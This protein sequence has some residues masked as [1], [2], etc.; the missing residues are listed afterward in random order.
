[1]KSTIIYVIILLLGVLYAGSAPSRCPGEY[2][3]VEYADDFEDYDLGERPPGW[4]VNRSPSDAEILVVDVDDIDGDGQALVFVNGTSTPEDPGRLGIQHFFQGDDEMFEGYPIARVK[5][6][7]DGDNQ[8]FYIRFGPAD[9]LILGSKLYADI[10]GEDLIPCED[11]A[12]NEWQEIS[13]RLNFKN[14]A[15]GIG[16]DG[17]YS[18][19]TLPVYG[20]FDEV[21]SFIVENQKIEEDLDDFYIDDVDIT[22]DHT[23]H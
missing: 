19:S 18:C 6:Y 23:R 16:L 8:D 9:A 2:D 22:N 1:M 5:I 21:S 7:L 4:G 12:I 17:H 11:L 20:S 10:P 13:I 14:Q 15:F 3:I